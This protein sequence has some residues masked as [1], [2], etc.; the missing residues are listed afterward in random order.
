MK[1]AD[2]SSQCILFIDCGMFEKIITNWNNDT[3]FVLKPERVLLYAVR[4]GDFLDLSGELYIKNE[5][6]I[7]DL[8]S[9]AGVM[10]A[11]FRNI[12]AVLNRWEYC[13]GFYIWDLPS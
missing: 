2:P 5:T 7:L 9:H 1:K 8:D 4:A 12:E 6:S 13:A 10:Y 11:C 3:E